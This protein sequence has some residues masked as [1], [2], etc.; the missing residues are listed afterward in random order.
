M[1]K[2]IQIDDDQTSILVGLGLSEGNIVKL[3]D[4]QPV[5]VNFVD[6]GDA[7]Y[8]A[9]DACKMFSIYYTYFLPKKRVR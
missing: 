9:H 3:K 1:I 5:K 7:S 6:M 2:F 4:G 8:H